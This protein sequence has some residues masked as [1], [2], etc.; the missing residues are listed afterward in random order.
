MALNPSIQPTI[1]PGAT[2]A[3]RAVSKHGPLSPNIQWRIWSTARRPRLIVARD[4][5]CDG[6][7]VLHRQMRH[8]ASACRTGFSLVRFHNSSPGCRSERCSIKLLTRACATRNVLISSPRRTRSIRKP[9]FRFWDF[10]L[11]LQPV[12]KQF[13]LGCRNLPFGSAVNQMAKEGSREVVPPNSRHERDRRRSHVPMLPSAG[14]PRQDHSMQ[15][16]GRQGVA[17]VW[18]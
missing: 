15:P 4:P 10:R 1:W 18:D 11:S 9:S 16:C 5:Q 14:P 6:L 12:E 13:Q 8:E 2:G 3:L 7:S 17:V